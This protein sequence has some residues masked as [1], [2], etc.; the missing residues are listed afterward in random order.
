[1]R[2]LAHRVLARMPLAEIAIRQIYWR[3]P[4]ARRVAHK[5][6]SAAGSRSKPPAAPHASA[7]LSE[8]ID[9]LKLLG[10]GAGDMLIVHAGSKVIEAVGEQP[11][12]INIALRDLIGARG[13]L[14]MPGFPLFRSEPPMADQIAGCVLP[15]HDYDPARTPLWTGLLAMDLLRTPGAM[16][17]SFPINPLIAIG[18]DVP[19]MF[20]AEWDEALPTACGRGSAWDYAVARGAKILMLGVDVAHSLTLNHQAEDGYLDSWPIAGWYRE[21]EY[22]VRIDGEWSERRVRER[23]P[24]WALHYGEHAL[25]ANMIENG[26]LQQA[27][28]GDLSVSLVDARAHIAF[29]NARKAAAFP[30]FGIRRRHWK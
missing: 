27:I 20:E 15:I 28:L 25:T 16:R 23:D 24:R 9:L 8:L 29:L 22:R 6:A 13:T 11:R 7:P 17:S 14:A 5:L 10:I 4:L 1:M 2:G 18:A 30:Y 19:K 3:V 26:D 21:R 12:A